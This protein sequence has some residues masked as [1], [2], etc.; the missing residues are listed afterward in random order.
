MYDATW[1][2][3]HIASLIQNQMEN[4]FVEISTCIC[5]M[6][7]SHKGYKQASTAQQNHNKNSHFN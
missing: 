2:F 5:K 4:M 6:K 7:A 1:Y 3:T